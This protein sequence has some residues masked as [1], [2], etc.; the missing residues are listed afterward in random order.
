MKNWK[1]IH[2]LYGHLVFN[3][4]LPFSDLCHS[5]FAISSLSKLHN[6]HSFKW[7]LDDVVVCKIPNIICELCAISWLYN[8][9][10]IREILFV[11]LILFYNL[12]LVEPTE[13]FSMLLDVADVLYITFIDWHLPSTG[14]LLGTLQL[15]F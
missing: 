15:H 14:Q 12:L 1:N 5:A 8:I 4:F 10:V 2:K 9:Y 13:C 6:W 11:F 3:S 7:L